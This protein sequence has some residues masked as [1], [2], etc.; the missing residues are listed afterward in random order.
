MVNG[1]SGSCLIETDEGGLDARWQPSLEYPTEG[2]GAGLGV[3]EWSVAPLD[4]RLRRC[5]VAVSA[6]QHQDRALLG[7][8]PRCCST[9]RDPVDTR[10]VIGP[11]S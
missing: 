9:R 8:S 5:V 7:G 10:P 4:S 11:G 3:A 2:S 6:C 1:M